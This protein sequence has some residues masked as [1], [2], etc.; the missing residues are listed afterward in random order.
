MT[1]EEAMT[2]IESILMTSWAFLN[3]NLSSVKFGDVPGEKASSDLPWARV[4]IQHVNGNQKSLANFEGSR[5]FTNSGILTI[6][7]FT[8]IGDGLVSEY[9]VGQFIRN[10]YRKAQHSNLWFRNV[11]LS[12]QPSDGAFAQINVLADFSYDDVT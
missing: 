1:A 3:F 11:R 8:P 4:T 5:R 12:E 10:A 7:V 2:Y 6:Q 9:R